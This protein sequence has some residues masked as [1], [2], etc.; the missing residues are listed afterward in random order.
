MCRSVAGRGRLPSLSGVD[1]IAWQVIIRYRIYPLVTGKSVTSLM[2]YQVLA[3]K[4]R[5]R[6]FE[7]MAGQEHVLRALVNALNQGRLHHAYLFTGT[8]GVGKTTIARILAKSLNCEQGISATPCDQCV[9]CIEVNE[10]RCID[11]IEVDAASRTKIADTLE[12]LDN[13]Q[14]APTRSRFKIYLIDEVHM[15]SGHSFNAL[16]K[17]LEE[18]PPHVKFLLATT[19]PQKLPVTILSRCLQFNLKNLSP[20]RIS[21][22]LGDILKAEQIEFDEG[23]LRQIGRA[24]DGSMRDAL[25]LTDQAIAYGDSSVFEADVST[26][27]GSVD[28]SRVFKI[29]EAL[30]AK[31]AKQVLDEV[32]DAANY[33]PNYQSLLE[34]LIS[35]LHRIAVVQVVP[36][37]NDSPSI[38][39]LAA[40]L[41]AEDVQLF[42]QIALLGL[43]D[44]P[45]NPDQRAGLEMVLL[46][47]LAFHPETMTPIA[48]SPQHDSSE[49]TP[50]QRDPDKPATTIP[51]KPASQALRETKALLQASSKTVKPAPVVEPKVIGSVN[52]DNLSSQPLTKTA[53]QGQK[54]KLLSSESLADSKQWIALVPELKLKGMTR[55]LLMQCAWQSRE[56][57]V[58]KLLLEPQYYDLINEKVHLQ[59]IKQAL[60]D[61]LGAEDIEIKFQSGSPENETPMIYQQRVKQENL[62]SAREIM[63]QDEN[64]KGIVEQ[65]GAVLDTDSIEIVQ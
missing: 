2:D 34:E 37:I 5:P 4:W 18:P 25:S 23:A 52:T 51:A 31:D 62:S 24:A 56:G 40:A 33:A 27:L 32:S 64:V 12:L 22:Y 48:K 21:S 47:M 10:G 54:K 36:E 19:D 53:T 43:K 58:I 59:R 17:T 28:S 16:L 42:Y 11:L 45:L 55:N 29:L 13:V 61:H 30:I 1:I 6:T 63:E 60:A 35:I 15:L 9:S 7:Q 49:I 8:R 57:Q 39:E 38:A 50:A 46:R 14:Y 3:R 41:V 65:F 26:M 20:E 44:L